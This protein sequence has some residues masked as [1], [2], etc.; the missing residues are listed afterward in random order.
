MQP[1]MCSRCGKNVAIVFITKIENNGQTKQEGLCLKCARELHV[2]PVDDL[3]GKMGISDDDLDSI[4]SEMMN[5]MN[6]VEDL[7]SMDG[8]DSEDDG[9]TATFPYLNRLFGGPNGQNGSPDTNGGNQNPQGAD[10]PR[11]DKE[12]GKGKHKFLD[13]YCIDLT[14]RA[15][16]GKLGYLVLCSVGGQ[17]RAREQL[18]SNAAALTNKSE[19]KMLAAYIIMSQLTSAVVSLIYRNS[20]FFCEI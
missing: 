16:A 9:K 11:A 3:I 15:R 7:L 13:N 17:A 14:E 19:K 10:R 5:A 2:K 18:I 20:C 12:P 6:G 8:D 1:T 4:S